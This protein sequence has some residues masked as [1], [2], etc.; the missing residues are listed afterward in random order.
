M[1][2]PLLFSYSHW[3]NPTWSQ[4][5]HQPV[6]ISQRSQGT[7]Q[8]E[9][10]IPFAGQTEDF[11]HKRQLPVIKEK[12]PLSGLTELTPLNTE[13]QRRM[14]VKPHRTQDFKVTR[15]QRTQ[16]IVCEPQTPN[17]G[18]PA[19]PLQ[20]WGW[21]QQGERLKSFHEKNKKK[22]GGGSGSRERE[23][24]SR[25]HRQNRSPKAW[26]HLS[27]Q[28]PNASLWL[29]VHSSS[30]REG[31][32]KVN[33]FELAA[34]REQCFWDRTQLILAVAYFQ[35]GH[36]HSFPFNRCLPFS[37]CGSLLRLRYHRLG[38]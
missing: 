2:W 32:L 35:D 38:A 33:G 34:S 16:K 13:G 30:Y 14:Q 9:G 1:P 20:V 7:E 10:W 26:V 28:M 17:S 37:H 18:T 24:E 29:V 25:D 8:G 12:Y 36:Y 21:D 23:G 6:Y 19:L 11:Q 31:G 4:R 15:R 27:L 3:L 22:E 5:A